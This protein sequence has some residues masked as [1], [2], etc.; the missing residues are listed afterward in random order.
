MSTPDLEKA[1]MFS[2]KNTLAAAVVLL[3]ASATLAAAEESGAATDRTAAAQELVA[4]M[5]QT[6][7][8]KQMPEVMGK[9]VEGQ[10][11]ATDPSAAQH[12]AT[13]IKASISPD[14]PAMKKLISG[15]ETLQTAAFANELSTDEMKQLTAFLKSEPYKKYQ[16][17]IIKVLASGAPAVAEYQK[18]VQTGI[19]EDLTKEQPKNAAAWNGLCWLTITTGGDPQRALGYCNT[20]LQINPRF[21]HALDSRGL[22][23]LKLGDFEHAQADYDAALKICPRLASSAYGRGVARIKRGD[24]VSGSEDIVAA[25]TADANLAARYASYGIK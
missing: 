12:A 19:Y 2:Y 24:F 13:F 22:V 18:D 20:A 5:D 3:T 23:Y 17:I 16:G 21:V 4:A 10:L 11:S 9:M 1:A 14:S 8:L 7:R 15:M 6:G 25:K